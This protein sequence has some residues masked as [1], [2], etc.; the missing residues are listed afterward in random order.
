MDKLSLHEGSNTENSC[1]V[2]FRS[3]AASP[4]WGSPADCWVE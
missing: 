1:F 2:K 3:P 4:P